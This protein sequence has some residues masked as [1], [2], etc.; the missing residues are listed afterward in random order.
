MPSKAAMLQMHECSF[1]IHLSARSH[2]VEG[3]SAVQVSTVVLGST[4]KRY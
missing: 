4:N 3:A 1:F 2:T